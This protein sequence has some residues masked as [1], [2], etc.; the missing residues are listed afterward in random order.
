MRPRK[1]QPTKTL[2]VR[3]LETGPATVHD[4]AETVGTTVRNT[5]VYLNELLE[6]GAIRVFAWE[7]ERRGPPL[8][9]YGVADGKPSPSK[10]R[11]RTPRE[12]MRQW[13]AKTRSRVG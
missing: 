2:L 1:E 13:R 3:E 9:V 8:P 12:H 11:A 6:E 5:R 4:L 10:P 7:R